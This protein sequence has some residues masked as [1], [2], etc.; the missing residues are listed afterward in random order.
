VF[1]LRTAENN[2]P[3]ADA[4]HG[5]VTTATE[6]LQHLDAAVADGVIDELCDRRQAA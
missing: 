1:R 4:Y 2:S 5:E 6:A 3:P